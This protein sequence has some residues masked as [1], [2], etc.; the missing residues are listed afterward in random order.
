MEID[1]VLQL[2][3]KQKELSSLQ[4]KYSDR[5]PDVLR[6]RREIQAL[7][8][9][10]KLEVK[11][12][13]GADGTKVINPNPIGRALQMQMNDLD[14]EIQT[15]RAYQERVRSQIAVLES[16]VNTAPI[17]SIELSKITRGYEITLKKYQD[18]L[19][20]NLESELSENMEKKLKGE[21]F[22]ILE[23]ANLPFY[24]IRPDRRKILIMG[25]FAG[26]ATGFGLAFLRDNFDTAFRTADEVAAYIAVP[27]LATMPAMLSRSSVL[28]R[29]KSQGF[30]VLTS[31][32]A[33]AIGAL[34]VRTFGSRLL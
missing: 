8:D 10:A 16:R 28:E 4:Q 15:V 3:L 11:K 5:H 22:Q 6:L 9:E 32:G 27:L 7:K 31:L 21:Q 14:T 24:P 12:A 13:D 34:L 25:I 17:R 33:L 23:T 18:L 19:A 30:L 2:E 20:K 29:R 26:L 1:P